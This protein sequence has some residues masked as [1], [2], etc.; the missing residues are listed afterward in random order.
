MV[1]NPFKRGKSDG[2][3]N[4]LFSMFSGTASYR[5]R[6]YVFLKGLIEKSWFKQPPQYFKRPLGGKDAQ[7]KHMLWAPTTCGVYTVTQT[8]ILDE[9]SDDDDLLNA[10]K[11]AYAI[12]FSNHP[13][14]LEDFL[15]HG[16]TPDTLQE[17]EDKITVLDTY[18]LESIT[19]ISPVTKEAYVGT[20]WLRDTIEK[21]NRENQSLLRDH[22]TFIKTDDIARSSSAFLHLGHQ[23]EKVEARIFLNP[24]YGKQHLYVS[25]SVFKNR[26]T[27]SLIN[28]VSLKFGGDETCPDTVRLQAHECAAKVAREVIKQNDPYD[29]FKTDSLVKNSGLF[30]KKVTINS[31]QKPANILSTI[32]PKSLTGMA[33]IAIAGGVLIKAPFLILGILSK[34]LKIGA[35][36]TLGKDLVTRTVRS[37]SRMFSTTDMIDI[38]TLD[39]VTHL[40]STEANIKKKA[41]ANNRGLTL[42]PKYL[43]KMEPVPFEIMADTFHDAQ[44]YDADTQDIEY[45]KNIL[46]NSLGT[47]PGNMVSYQHPYL[48]L[49]LANGLDIPTIHFLPRKQQKKIQNKIRK[50]F[51]Q[52]VLHDTLTMNKP[53]Q[54]L[55]GTGISTTKEQIEMYMHTRDLDIDDQTRCLKIQ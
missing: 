19:K 13:S 38:N 26:M 32:D 44:E 54:P 30:L 40:L 3:L 2:T 21:H 1:K 6:E 14:V 41:K 25:Q 29:L 52:E 50:A 10:L 45:A 17:I 12:L 42:N 8:Y 47:Q 4:M 35:A 36:V 23:N 43:K 34:S 53:F 27:R 49:E 31:I 11:P 7:Q 39:E 46:L 22:G 9:E 37:I 28:S 18:S 16:S 33:T 48:K 20:S 55:G 5:D 24:A 15:L 51:E